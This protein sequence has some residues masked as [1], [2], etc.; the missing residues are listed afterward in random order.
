MRLGFLEISKEFQQ[1]EKNSCIFMFGV[2][3]YLSILCVGILPTAVN[4]NIKADGPLYS[5][6]CMNV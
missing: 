3:S 6:G 4:G 5:H 2:L 1:F